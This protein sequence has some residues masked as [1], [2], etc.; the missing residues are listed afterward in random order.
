MMAEWLLVPP[1][2]FGIYVLLVGAL[3]LVGRWRAATSPNTDAKRLSYAS[4]ESDS[5]NVTPP[6]YQQFF[7]VALFFAVLHLGALLA[8]SGGITGP[9]ALYLGGLALT[10]FVLI[11]N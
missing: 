2:A 8:A 11:L 1:V 7:V 10:L 3:A 6:G 9:V 5:H 4:G